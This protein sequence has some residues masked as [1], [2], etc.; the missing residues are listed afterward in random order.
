MK[1]KFGIR[2]TPLALKLIAIERKALGGSDA[3]AVERLI[4]RGSTSEDA[5]NAILE[6]ASKDPQLSALIPA[7][8]SAKA[9]KGF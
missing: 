3:D 4:Y 9:K 5:Q 1:T 7:L 8:R 6:E 2:I